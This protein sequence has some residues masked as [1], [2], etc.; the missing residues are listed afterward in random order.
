MD[1]PTISQLKDARRGYVAAVRQLDA[2]LRR[3]DQ[4]GIPMDPG[5]GS[6]PYPWSAEHVQIMLTVHAAFGRVIEARRRWDRLRRDEARPHRR[7]PPLDTHPSWPY[8]GR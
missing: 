1:G 8:A 7:L 6:E 4:C 5:P 3:F 2:A